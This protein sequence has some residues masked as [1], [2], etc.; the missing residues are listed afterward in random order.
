MDDAN[1]ADGGN[2]VTIGR[3]ASVLAE[4]TGLCATLRAPADLPRGVSDFDAFLNAG[5][6]ALCVVLHAFKCGDALDAPEAPRRVASSSSRVRSSHYVLG[7]EAT[8][9]AWVAVRRRRRRWI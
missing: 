7:A 4:E 9:S 3:V 1:I 5:D 8:S 2:G 6:F